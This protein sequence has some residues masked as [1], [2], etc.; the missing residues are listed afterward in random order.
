MIALLIALQACALTVVLRAQY[1]ANPVKFLLAIQASG[2][3]LATV[4]SGFGAAFAFVYFRMSDAQ[5]SIF[6]EYCVSNTWSDHPQQST[7]SR[8]KWCKK[9]I[10]LACVVSDTRRQCIKRGWS[11]EPH[12]IVCL[13]ANEIRRFRTRRG[14]IMQE[15]EPNTAIDE[16]CR[17][18]PEAR[19]VTRNT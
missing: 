1:K 13:I 8:C 16:D 14:T 4:A 9:W 19:P 11:T 5:C 17:C 7:A 6:A 12:S 2:P 18:Q 15:L 10:V 3:T